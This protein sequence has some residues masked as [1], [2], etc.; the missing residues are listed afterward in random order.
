MIKKTLLILMPLY[1]L[2]IVAIWLDGATIG[3]EK[4]EYAVVL[5]NQVCNRSPTCNLAQMIY[6]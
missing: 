5:G 1:F 6:A 4:A 3:Y 2:G